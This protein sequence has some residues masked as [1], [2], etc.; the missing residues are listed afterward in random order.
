MHEFNMILHFIK[1]IRM[2]ESLM[3]TPFFFMG[4]VFAQPKILIITLPY[5]LLLILHFYLLIQSIYLL[6]SYFGKKHDR[7][8][9]RFQGITITNKH[10]ELLFVLLSI[11]TLVISLIIDYINNWNGSALILINYLLWIFYASSY[12]NFKSNFLMGSL[13]HFLSGIINFL[14]GFTTESTISYAAI[15]ISIYFSLLFVAGHMHHMVIDY[16]A[17]KSAELK[18]LPS[19]IGIKKT[20]LLSI[21]SILL[22]S[23]YFVILS[24][25]NIV[26][27][28]YTIPVVLACLVHLILYIIV[29][30]NLK[31]DDRIRY[32]RNY[33]IIHAFSLICLILIYLMS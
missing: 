25:F 18:T 7:V 11:I 21:A 28:V 23:L 6:N 4:Y 3:M 27:V 32:R 29:K 19:I 9:K 17:D 30:D 12:V 13:V 14:I 31:F 1:K 15:A 5:I 24:L 16:E 10:T 2:L 8:N 26:P 22:A 20:S 33:R